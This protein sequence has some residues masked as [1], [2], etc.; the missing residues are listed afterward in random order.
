[1]ID[2]INHLYAETDHTLSY[3]NSNKGTSGDVSVAINI[4]S[5]IGYTGY[6]L[7]EKYHFEGTPPYAL[8]AQRERIEFPPGCEA[9]LKHW[10]INLTWAFDFSAGQDVQFII[11][12][13]VGSPD[14]DYIRIGATDFNHTSYQDRSAMDDTIYYYRIVAAYRKFYFNKVSQPLF[15]AVP[16]GNV[17]DDD[18]PL[19]P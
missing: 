14:G 13:A 2:P 17:Y 3:E 5:N 19:A 4:K 18:G 10:Y 12:R 16:T 8:N 9:P 6:Q 7:P 11:E 15:V 1:M